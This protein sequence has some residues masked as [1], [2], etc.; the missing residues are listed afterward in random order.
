MAITITPEQYA[1]KQAR[2][3]KAANAD[4]RRG[5]AAVTEAPTLKAIA[6]KDKMLQNLTAAVNDGTWE[7]GLRRVSLEEW[8][9]RMIEKGIPRI[10]AGI[11]AAHDKVVN[12]ATELLAFETTLQRKIVVM[13]DLSLEDNI[14]RATE[15]MRGMATFKRS[16]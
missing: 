5:V 8:K 16:G 15:W 12:F 3:L 7:A 14:L 4:I 13:P 9:A 10:A 11:D 1:E 6:A 2:N